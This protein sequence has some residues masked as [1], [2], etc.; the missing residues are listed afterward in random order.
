MPKEVYMHV[1]EV[2]RNLKKS[3][4]PAFTK[5]MKPF[6]ASEEHQESASEE[7]QE[8]TSEEVQE[9]QDGASEEVQE[10]QEG[11][12]V[13]DAELAHLQ[14]HPPS[15]PKPFQIC[16]AGAHLARLQVCIRLE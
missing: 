4:L 10:D 5:M 9:D 12:L 7:D 6:Q 11:T 2:M 13:A 15:L 16:P 3:F 1:Q 14:V 8:S